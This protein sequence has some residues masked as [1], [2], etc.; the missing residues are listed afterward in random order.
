MKKD[1]KLLAPVLDRLIDTSENFNQ[2]QAQIQP[3]H[4]IRQL[5]ESVRRDMED[6]LNTRIRCISPPVIYSAEKSILDNSLLNY[7]L[8]D[9]AT[10][11]LVSEK[12][13]LDFCRQIERT[14]QR[15]EP[16]IKSVKVS[17]NTGVDR[18][19]PTIRF[20]VEAVLHC[21]PAPELI[22]FDSAMNPITQTI[23]VTEAM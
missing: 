21:N 7:G 12:H 19:D 16:R 8:P 4:V 9:L 14:I 17:S 20:K 11:N 13:R 6:L 22:V 2:R 3:H 18:E 5:R 10:V 1:K 23:N 15:F